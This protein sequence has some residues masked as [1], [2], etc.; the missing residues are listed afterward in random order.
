MASKK[1]KKESK[2]SAAS[3]G[4]MNAI[5]RAAKDLHDA[6]VM[7]AKTMREFDRGC[8]TPVRPFSGADILALRRRERVSQTLFANY[9]NVSKGVV[10]QWERDERRPV[11]TALKLLALAEKN[12]LSSIA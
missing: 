3:S 9:L 2:A 4:L 6:G 5:H 8:L 7:D 12:G 11:G 1:S 10:S